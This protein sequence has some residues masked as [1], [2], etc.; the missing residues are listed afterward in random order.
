[1]SVAYVDKGDTSGLCGSVR[2]VRR[3]KNAVGER[4]GRGFVEKTQAFEASDTGSLEP[5]S[6]FRVGQMRRL[7]T[8]F[9]KTS[10]S[11]LWTQLFKH[12]I[13]YY[14]AHFKHLSFNLFQT[15]VQTTVVHI[16]ILKSR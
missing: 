13:F 5:G 12:T 9:Q 14:P 10:L 4:R 8:L 1:M 6:A 15:I 7:C 16:P 11:D 3:S 2:Q